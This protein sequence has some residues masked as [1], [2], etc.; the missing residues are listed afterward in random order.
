[1]PADDDL[2]EDKRQLLTTAVGDVKGSIHANDQKVAAALVVNGLLFTGVVTVLT[3]LE[4]IYTAAQPWQR[5]AGGALLAVSLVNFAASVSYLLWAMKPYRPEAIEKKMEGLYP[6]V[7]FP[8]SDDLEGD[9]PFGPWRER[10]DGLRRS[11]VL[12]ELTAE[13]LK[14]ADILH[15]ESKRASQG[16][17]WLAIE[18]LFVLALLVFVAVVAVSQL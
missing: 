4:G 1:V 18:G 7:F 16:Y 8:R 11:D 17:K 14:L 15:T 12:D 6:R 9:D 13:T 2:Y 10:V 5:W 3:R